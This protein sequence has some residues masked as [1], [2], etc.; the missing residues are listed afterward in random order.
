MNIQLKVKQRW[1]MWVLLLIAYVAPGCE[2]KNVVDTNDNQNGNEPKEITWQQTALDS[3]TI[4]ALASNSGDNLFAA[5]GGDGIF[6]SMDR[7]ATWTTSE[8]RAAV[9]ALSISSKGDIFAA[10][11][12]GFT[13]GFLFRS[14]DAG[15]TWERLNVGNYSISPTAPVFHLSGAIFFGSGR[16]DETGGGLFRSLDNGDTWELITSYPTDQSAW[17]LAINDRGD[18]FAGSEAGLFRST[19]SAQTWTLIEKPEFERRG[20]LSLAISQVSGDIFASATGDGVFRSRDNGSTWAFTGLG[21][22]GI[23]AM[24]TNSEGEIFAAS[25]R[26]SNLPAEGVYYSEDNGDTWSQINRGLTNLN[27]F[28]LTLDG[29]GFLYAGTDGD[30]VFRT[31]ESTIKE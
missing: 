27:I 26:I 22:P 19:D 16:S 25:S 14:T 18:L 29:S 3:L 1:L 8:L 28:S 13:S 15:G 6:R 31:V 7:G 12:G 20:I 23:F 9:I 2:D 5:T 21:S 24:M 17:P 11:T 30:G 10:A 4:Y